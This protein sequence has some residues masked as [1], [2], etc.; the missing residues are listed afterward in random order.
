MS[1]TAAA[2]TRAG[3]AVL[4]V[5]PAVLLALLAVV[6]LRNAFVYPAI[7]GYDAQEAL[8]YANGL[9]RD[10]QLPDEAGSYYTPPGFFAVAGVAIQL[11]EALGMDHPERLGQLVSALAV[12]G[13][14]V[15]VLVLGRLIWPCRRLLHVTALAFL[16]ACPVVF[17]SA[18]MF[19]PEALS[20]F[21]STVAIA[22]AAHILIR[23]DHRARSAVAL[24]AALGVA[25]L[26]RA[27]TLWTLGVVVVVLVAALVV[28]RVDRR[29]LARV[30]VV[31][32]G[33]AATLT[34]PWY[35]YQ[36]TRYGNPVFD[37]PQPEVSIW[38]RR[39]AAFF[40]GSG[41]PDVITRPYTPA[42]RDRFQPLA[43]AETWGDY[44]GTWEWNGGR[45]EPSSEEKRSLVTQSVVG[46][47]FTALA[48]AG[49]L[50]LLALSIR[51][52]AREP[53]RD[54]VALMPAAALAGVLYFATAYP[55]TDGDT[56]KGSFMLT[57]VPAWALCFGFAFDAV[58]ARH[59]WL[60][61]PLSALFAVAAL[62]SIR[63]GLAEVSP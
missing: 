62:V 56:A 52:P 13:S 41:L 21:A 47:L 59:R 36:A 10:G 2:V 38:D 16:V 43:F 9:V 58:V 37:R 49:W 57:A 34:A 19:H 32:L 11:G 12:V 44:F 1:S 29:A 51:R 17:K 24:G 50:A 48:I 26:V 40:L 39:P 5:A 33:T 7:A 55:T 8:D 14:G 46:L 30:L 61:A 22:L 3:G 45:G 63:F 6:A 20:L 25:Q 18:A 4:R 53:G 28:R 23:R 15:L 27:W 42:A 31:M 60:V 35:G 54:L